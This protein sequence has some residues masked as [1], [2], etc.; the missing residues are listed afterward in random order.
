MYG[1]IVGGIFFD[2]GLGKVQKSP[3]IV[4]IST[5]F[6][7]LQS[8]NVLILRL[9]TYFDLANWIVQPYNTDCVCIVLAH[10][11]VN[12]TGSIMMTPLLVENAQSLK[13]LEF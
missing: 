13:N 2:P 12:D 1:V 6:M 7:A 4:E 5:C 11:S 10:Q 8:Q 3:E 9:W